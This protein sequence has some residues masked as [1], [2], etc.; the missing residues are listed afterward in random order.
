[1]V[2]LICI[3][4]A[5]TMHLKDFKSYSQDDRIVIIKTNYRALALRYIMFSFLYV[6]VMCIAFAS[7]SDF[8]SIKTNVI[9]MIPLSFICITVSLIALNLAL[10]KIK[11]EHL[12]II[13]HEADSK[14]AKRF[15]F[16]QFYFIFTGLIFILGI[17]IEL[18]RNEW[19]LWLE[20]FVI[21]N[22]TLILTWKVFTHRIKLK[23]DIEVINLSDV[24]WLFS[25]ATVIKLAVINIIGV[26]LVLCGLI[27]LIFMLN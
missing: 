25:S 3:Y 6:L 21:I 9:K 26:S 7:F 12:N 14:L 19:V 16:L 27:T 4:L 8:S 2:M 20:S 18:A 1:M 11:P 5:L 10:R 13:F 17:I 23:P 15:K 22:I 24:N